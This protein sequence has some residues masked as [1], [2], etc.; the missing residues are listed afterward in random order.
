MVDTLNADFDSQVVEVPRRGSKTTTIFCLLSGRCA[1]RPGYQV[2]FSA[3]SGVA[4]SRRLREWA[5]RLDAIQPP[6]DQEL[7]PWLRGAKPKRPPQAV[8][9]FGPDAVPTVEPKSR[10]FKIMRGEVGKGIYWDNGST[11][12]VLKPDADSYRGEAADV[13]WLDEAQEIDPL[14]GAELLAGIV[15]LQDT[16][17]GSAILISG[18]AGE[19]RVGP[20]WE[21]LE[22]LRKGSPDMGGIDFAVDDTTPWELIEDIEEAM[23]LVAEV[24][25][26][27][28]TLTTMAKMRKNWAKLPRPQWAREYLSLWPESFG[29]KAIPAEWWENAALAKKKTKPARVA[30][31]ADIKP[32]GGVAAIVVAWRD[33]RGVAYIEVVEHRVGTAWM[34]ERYG[35]LSKRYRGSTIAYDDIAE[36]KATATETAR[37]KP[38]PRLRVQTY[39]EH[40]AGC[41]Q[42]MRD[43]ER[44]K[45]KHFG[46]T[47]LDDA[48]DR[49]AKREVRGEQGVWLWGVE[50]SGG[51]ITTLVAATRAL[52]NWDQWFAN[53]SNSTT[54]SIITAGD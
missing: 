44:G 25:P 52:R 13:S 7:P 2:T 9:L 10:G 37:M 46:Q 48:V 28:G 32:G 5:G 34:P 29:V 1:N 4:G 36:G 43:L 27:I 45:L 18:T 39:R 35:E 47:S 51:D 26:G 8:A 22:Q 19:A 3:Q 38:K 30:F 11:M 16:K 50:A 41:V 15:P 33:S 24:H 20:F 31:G 21:F 17:E 54:S 12:L 53:K 49:A 14:E 40:A 42:I 23:K 6:D